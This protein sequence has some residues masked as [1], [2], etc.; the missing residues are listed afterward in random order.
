MWIA[1]LLAI[2]A[3]A[4]VTVAAIVVVAASGKDGGL[5]AG[6]AHQAMARLTVANRAISHELTRLHHGDSVRPARR[7]VR[8]AMATTRDLA[9]SI[10]GSSDLALRVRDV[11]EAE[12]AYLDAVGST[13]ANP[14]SA[15]RAKVASRAITLRG[16]LRRVPA[17]AARDVRGAGELVRFSRSRNG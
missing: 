10:A 6:A 5:S 2:S 4:G 12:E 15:L 17:A 1:R 14:S 8:K 11:L 13:L 9:A 7:A 16:A 3:L